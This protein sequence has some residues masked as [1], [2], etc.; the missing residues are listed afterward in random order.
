MIM[1]NTKAAY[2][3]V[4]YTRIFRRLGVQNGTVLVTEAKLPFAVVG[5]DVTA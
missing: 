5:Y 3:T 2:R 1:N 4:E